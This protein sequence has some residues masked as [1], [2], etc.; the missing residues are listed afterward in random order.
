MFLNCTLGEN[1]VE[2]SVSSCAFLTVIILCLTI[3]RLI[4]YQQ[5]GVE[6]RE[7]D[8]NYPIICLE[9]VFFVFSLIITCSTKITLQIQTFQIVIKN[10]KNSNKTLITPS[11]NLV[12]PLERRKRT[13]RDQFEAERLESNDLTFHYSNKQMC[14]TV[15]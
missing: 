1:L 10:E 2:R 15:L 3:A 11:S 8:K 14:H 7:I 6:L 4:T 9:I 13:S 12:S 5:A